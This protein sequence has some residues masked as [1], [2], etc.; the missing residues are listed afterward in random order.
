MVL[1]DEYADPDGDEGCGHLVSEVEVDGRVVRLHHVIPDDSA[2]HAPTSECGCGPVLHQA[3][4]GTWVYEHVD[5]DADPDSAA[6]WVH[7]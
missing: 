4:P 5:Q 2:P 7:T 6:P 3:D 1:A